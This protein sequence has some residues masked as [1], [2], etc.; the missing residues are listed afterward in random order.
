MLIH[1]QNLYG[2]RSKRRTGRRGT[3]SSGTGQQSKNPPCVLSRQRPLPFKFFQYFIPQFDATVSSYSQR[4]TLKLKMEIIHHYFKGYVHQILSRGHLRNAG[5]MNTKNSVAA[6][7]WYVR[8]K[9]AAR[10]KAYTV[11]GGITLSLGFKLCSRY[12]VSLRKLRKIYACILL[13][14][15]N[16]AVGINCPS[17]QN[18]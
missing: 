4:H 5:V 1:R 6:Y 10:L 17:H 16:F 12:V 18:S 13:Y 15:S 7:V 8:L 14:Q 3:Q 11:F 9:M 2:P